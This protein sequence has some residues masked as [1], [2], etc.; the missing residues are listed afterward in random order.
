KYGGI[1]ILVLGKL[2]RQDTIYSYLQ[3]A[4]EKIPLCLKINI[5]QTVVVPVALY[6][7][8]CWP[9]TKRHVKALDTMELG[10]EE[11]EEEEEEEKKKEEEEEEEEEGLGSCCIK[12][13]CGSSVVNIFGNS[14][15]S[16]EFTSLKSN[17]IIL[18]ALDKAKKK[19]DLLIEDQN[20]RWKKRQAKEEAKLAGTDRSPR[21]TAEGVGRPVDRLQAVAGSS[22]QE[23]PGSERTGRRRPAM[24]AEMI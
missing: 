24:A 17:V 3:Q 22:Q 5:Y 23:K 10:E 8:E 12:S 2:Q 19:E 20:G 11:E 14:K 13:Q 16:F 15:S 9:A 18:D 7:A 1:S 21:G 6:G 4:V